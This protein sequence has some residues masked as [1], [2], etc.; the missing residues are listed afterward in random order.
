MRVLMS[1]TVSLLAILTCIGIGMRFDEYPKGDTVSLL[2]IVIVF[3]LLYKAQM[4]MYKRGK[5]DGQSLLR[6][7]DFFVRKN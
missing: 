6:N 3:I 5:L 1:I 2:Y 7:L 4:A